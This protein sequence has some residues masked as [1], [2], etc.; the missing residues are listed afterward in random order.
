[1]PYMGIDS[2]LTEGEEV[3]G[4]IEDETDELHKSDWEWYITSERIVKYGS[5]PLGGE[6][7]HDISIDKVEGISFETGRRNAL[8][9]IGIL[10]LL[11]TVFVAILP[12]DMIQGFG[13]VLS[14]LVF[15]GV[16]TT[17][18]FFAAWYLSKRSYLQIH[19]IEPA[20]RWRIE[21]E[22]SD[23]VSD[24]SE[25]KSFAVTLREKTSQK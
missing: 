7:F 2:Y 18:V 17:L 24:D 16:A 1:M 23:V 22:E 11:L 13:S 9:V 6:R 14:S 19:G 25:I 21:M 15:V 20:D 10:S 4:Y 8:L 5:D 3:E 12:P